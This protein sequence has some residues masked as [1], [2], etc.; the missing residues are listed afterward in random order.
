MRLEAPA[1]RGITTSK[2]VL[3]AGKAANLQNQSESNSNWVIEESK[4]EVDDTLSSFVSKD[5]M[6]EEHEEEKKVQVVN[7]TNF[8]RQ[9]LNVAGYKRSK[10]INDSN[11]FHRKDS[12]ETKH[13]NYPQ[14]INGHSEVNSMMSDDID[15][16]EFE[17]KFKNKLAR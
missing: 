16:E 13:L 6:L 7:N 5:Y 2:I 11:N 8:V 3:N 12:E 10:F 1:K 17:K 4:E 15:D 9:T 14:S